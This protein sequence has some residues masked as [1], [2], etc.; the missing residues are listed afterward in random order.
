MRQKLLP[1]SVVELDGPFTHELIH[2]RGIRLHAAMAGRPGDPLIVLIH[3]SFGGWF[4]FRFVIEPLARRGF[5]VAAV[6]LRGFGMSDKPPADFGQDIRTPAGDISGLIQALGYDRA[7]VVGDDTGG[8]LVWALATERPERVQGLVSISSAHPVDLRRAIASRPWD[9]A[10]IIA[11]ATIFRLPAGVLRHCLAAVPQLY[12]IQLTAN[13]TGEF[14][15]ELFDAALDLRIKS[16]RIKNSMRA[17]IWNHRMLTAAVPHSWVDTPISA[18]VMFL[19]ADQGLWGPLLKRTRRRVTGRLT[20]MTLP[21]AKNV[22]QLEQ[23]EA[24]AD[25][26][27]AWAE[28]LVAQ[29]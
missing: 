26:I 12:R 7:I 19:H 20:E 6:D 22:P 13:T 24:F 9:F 15:G 17:I 8:S 5:R 3:S 21:G 4:D 16:A 25:T 23:P 14:R 28:E 1:P 2:T 27:A 10:V 11:R 29:A 18:P